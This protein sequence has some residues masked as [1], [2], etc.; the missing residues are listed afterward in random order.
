MYGWRRDVDDNA[1]I[2]SVASNILHVA[3]EHREWDS[4]TINML[5][6]IKSHV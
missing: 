1:G 3:P 4:K 5:E 6:I 2:K